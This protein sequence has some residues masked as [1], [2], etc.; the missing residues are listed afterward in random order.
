M[1]SNGQFLLYDIFLAMIIVL[2]VVVGITFV[3]SQEDDYGID[4]S[5]SGETLD[6]L[7]SMKVHDRNLL[8]AL[9]LGDDEAGRIV[10]EVMGSD[11]YTLRDLTLN[12]TLSLRRA[13]S[14]DEVIAA[15]RMVE[16]HEYELAFYV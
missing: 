3:L 6:L 8:L 16:S 14:Y 13:S 15:R 9:S 7:A 5:S 10:S 1:N 4:Y 12:K 11:A 2:V